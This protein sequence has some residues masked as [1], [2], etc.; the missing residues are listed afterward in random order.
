MNIQAE[1]KKRSILIAALLLVALW[2]TVIAQESGTWSNV[3]VRKIPETPELVKLG[4]KLYKQACLYCHGETG[5]GDGSGER[6]LLTK[7]RDF[8]SGKFK[9]RSTSTGFLPTDGDLFR[10]ITVGFPEFR[11][12]RFDYLTPKERWALI[13]YLKRFSSEFGKRKL[14]FPADIGEPPPLTD[15]LLAIGEQFYQDAECWKCHGKDG[16]G[17]GPSAPTLKDDLGHPSRV[18]AF[19]LGPQAFKRGPSPR[20]IVQTFMTG[21]TGTPMPSYEES[22]TIEQAWAVAYYVESLAKKSKGQE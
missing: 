11:M 7:P 12:P 2:S 15:E 17:D 21:L 6:Y 18:A 14:E 4:E 5:K 20:D 13:Y 1:W 16:Q 22:F 8:T 19:A 3:K 9:L 10:T